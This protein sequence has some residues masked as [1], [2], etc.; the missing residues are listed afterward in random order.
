[1]TDPG[2]P[3]GAP[4]VDAERVAQAVERV[5]T[6]ARLSAGSVGAEVATYLPGRRVR[7][8][9]VDAGTVEVHVVAR[10]PAVLP[11][12]GTAV[13]AA[14]APLVGGRAIEVVIEDLDVPGVDEPT[15]PVA[16]LPPAGATEGP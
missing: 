9:L 7:G 16:E 2:A 1:V 10:W 5:P 14:A 6:V 11:E 8:V 3:P 15:E 13:R 12:V 4:P